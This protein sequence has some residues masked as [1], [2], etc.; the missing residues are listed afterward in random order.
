MFILA[1]VGT[2]VMNSYPKDVQIPV[3]VIVPVLDLM[4]INTSTY[5]E[6]AGPICYHLTDINEYSSL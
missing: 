5:K 6:S 4:K 1:V 3:E 2:N